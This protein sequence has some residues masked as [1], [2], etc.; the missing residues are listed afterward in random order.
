MPM[1]TELDFVYAVFC[2]WSA[3]FSLFYTDIYNFSA[4][5]SGLPF[6]VCVV[7]SSTIKKSRI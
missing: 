3:A 4:G 5:I 6:L 2:L 1:N 7:S